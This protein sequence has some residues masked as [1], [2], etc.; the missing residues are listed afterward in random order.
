MRKTTE[1]LK[2]QAEQGGRTNISVDVAK[3]M[4][5]TPEILK[6]QVEQGGWTTWMRRTVGRSN[7]ESK[8]S[9]D[10]AKQ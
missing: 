2:I 4:R 10:I 5:K 6:I 7:V 9:E 3:Q 1:I 8:I